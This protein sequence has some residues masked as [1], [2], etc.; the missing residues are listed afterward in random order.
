[1]LK[2]L[3]M[4]A[5]VKT[6]VLLFLLSL[7]VVPIGTYFLILFAKGYRPNLPEKKL[8]PTGLLVAT[9]T[10]DGAQILVNGKVTSA[11]NTT[12]SLSPATYEI[13]IKKDGFQPWKKTLLQSYPITLLS[14]R[15][16]NGSTSIE[17][18]WQ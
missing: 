10:P 8:D 15:D 7:I 4:Q 3:N 6:R 5:V 14:N 11:T 16:I 17:C 12:L 13:E 9:S 1:M 18:Y 2:L